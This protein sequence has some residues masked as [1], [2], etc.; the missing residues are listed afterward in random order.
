[1]TSR[2]QLGPRA[3]GGTLCVPVF[4]SFMEKAVKKYGG[5]KF[6][7]PPGGYFINID[8][9]T[10][11]R[12]A[13][14][15]QGDNVIAEYFRDGEDPIIGLA[16]MVDGGFGMGSNLPLFA[17]G[18]SDDPNGDRNRDNLQR[19]DQSHSQQG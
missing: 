12:A 3:F 2:V 11:A 10:G 9:F 17:Y 6:Q 16:S 1:M 13:G 14:W 8:R 19:Q 18:E 15:C 7:V 5:T 4:Q